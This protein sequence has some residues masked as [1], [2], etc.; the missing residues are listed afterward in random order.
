MVS[1]NLRQSRGRL[2]AADRHERIRRELETAG[3][4]TVPELATALNVSQETIRRDLRRLEQNGDVSVVHGGATRR[5][6]SEPDLAQRS[7][8]RTDAK[9][10]IARSAAKFVPEGGTVLID[11]GSTT[12]VL[13]TELASHPRFT[14]ATNSLGVA[15]ILA[16]AGHQV[17]MLPGEIDPNDESAMSAETIDALDAYRFDVAF[18]GAGGISAAAGLTDYLPLAARFRGRLIVSAN[19]AY[20]L[21][22]RD[23]FDRRTPYPVPNFEQI[24]AIISDARPTGELASW[25]RRRG[26]RV[27]KS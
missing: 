27:I 5:R 22:D 6:F 7:D 17:F 8:Q 9:R 23:K 11:S 24:S 20:L 19:A 21:A 12:Q 25:L 13:A 18:I 26:V 16:R 10:A 4:V 1:R 14:V 15:T 2:L 3:S